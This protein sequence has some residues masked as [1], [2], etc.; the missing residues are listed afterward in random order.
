M[1]SPRTT[2][3]MDSISGAVCRSCYLPSQPQWCP[4]H[5]VGR[6]AEGQSHPQGPPSFPHSQ[7][8][9][10]SEGGAPGDIQQGAALSMCVLGVWVGRGLGSHQRRRSSSSEVRGGSL[11][12]VPRHLLPQP[13]CTPQRQ[14]WW[15]LRL[16]LTGFQ[17]RLYPPCSLGKSVTCASVSSSGKRSHKSAYSQGCCAAWMR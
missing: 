16:C 4:E 2:R 12:S 15:G 5:Q 9:E 8:P 17:S 13:P 11:A 14:P 6:V 7:D 10:F 3:G 1:V